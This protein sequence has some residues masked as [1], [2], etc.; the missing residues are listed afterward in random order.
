MYF[1]ANISVNLIILNYPILH[2]P[3]LEFLKQL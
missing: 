3:F 2:L 1:I